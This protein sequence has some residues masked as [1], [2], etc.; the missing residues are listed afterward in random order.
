MNLCTSKKTT[1]ITSRQLVEGLMR[2]DSY[3]HSVQPIEL[4]E[5]H[6]SWVFLTGQWA[7]KVKKPVNLGFV[8]FSTLENR[9]HFCREELVR[10]QYFA[11]KL[12]CEVVPITIADGL[13]RMGGHGTAVDYAVKMT[14]FDESQIALRLVEE[15]QLNL[16]EVT[17]LAHDVA[18]FH[19]AA[20]RAETTDADWGTEAH[21]AQA[22][23]ENFPILENLARQVG[24]SHVLECIQLWTDQQI[25][26]LGNFLEQRRQA[27]YIRQ[28]HGDLHL[29]NI[30][31]WQC[32]LTPFDCI[33]FNP[34]FYWVDVINE[35]AFLAMDL[36]EHSRSDLK[37]TFLNAYLEATGDYGSLMLL[38]FYQVYR[39][40]VRAKVCELRMRQLEDG[41]AGRQSL[42][43]QCTCYLDMAADYLK[44]APL[45]LT[46]TYGMS[47]SGKSS[48]SQDWAQ[49]TG[50]V[51][52]RSDIERKR[53][54]GLPQTRR[55]TQK[56]SSAIYSQEGTLQTYHRLEQLAGQ[57]LSA[58]FPVIIDATFLKWSQRDQFRQLAER[59]SVPFQILE[60]SA[61]AEVLLQRIRQRTDDGGDASDATEAVLNLQM[62]N[63]EPLTAIERSYL[64]K[65]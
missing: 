51:R 31:R 29:G 6:I 40:M 62:A 11:P 14:Q 35:I 23:R 9:Q 7:Y 10:N 4:R 58:G 57:I 16:A 32:R 20:R 65:F 52:L 63:C 61:E 38:P 19:S 37:W 55:P 33:E 46:I 53:L 8:D 41:D 1:E 56:Q 60:F 3:L 28:C 49:R 34:D 44:P 50:A 2:P 48:G 45:S 21:I 43:Q 5:T 27:G 15:G 64:V 25:L 18:A 36:D 47:G 24:L 39:A 42:L 22:A 12:Y 13:I 26:Q 54:F 59:M 17:Q 30:V